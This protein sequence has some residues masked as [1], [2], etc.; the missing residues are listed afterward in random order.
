MD[1]FIVRERE[2]LNDKWVIF[3]SISVRLETIVQALDPETHWLKSTT[4]LFLITHLSVVMV[5]WVHFAWKFMLLWSL[6]WYVSTLLFLSK[7]FQARHLSPVANKII[8]EN[9]PTFFINIGTDFFT[10]LHSI[11]STKGGLLNWLFFL[12]F[13]H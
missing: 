13:S 12:F 2:D 10:I 1:N 5:N 9:T 3:Y 7:S 8:M 6:C 4:R 11:D